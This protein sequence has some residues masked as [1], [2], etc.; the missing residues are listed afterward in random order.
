MGFGR[1]PSV[2]QLLQFA[3][4]PLLHWRRFPVGWLRFGIFGARSMSFKASIWNWKAMEVFRLKL[5]S[6]I[7]RSPRDEEL[8]SPCTVSVQGLF[9]M[10][11]I[12]CKGDASHDV[13][14]GDVIGRGAFSMVA[15]LSCLEQWAADG[16]TSEL[17]WSVWVQ[18]FHLDSQESPSFALENPWQ[19]VPLGRGMYLSDCFPCCHVQNRYR[20]VQTRYDIDIQDHTHIILH[21]LGSRVQLAVL[22]FGSSLIWM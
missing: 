8:G 22:Q 19:L 13:I 2:V 10:Q 20:E 18:L 6:S 4:V 7:W 1:S 21:L 3:Q 12:A 17:F 16:T 5:L 15:T 14:I 11:T 9:L